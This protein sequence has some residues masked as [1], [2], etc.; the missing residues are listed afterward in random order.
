MPSCYIFKKAAILAIVFLGITAFAQHNV[1]I[2]NS[3]NQGFARTH[4]ITNGILNVLKE[5]KNVNVHVDYMDILTISKHNPQHKE[6]HE[7]G[8]FTTL[9]NKYRYVEFDMVI[10]I[11]HMAF[12]FA[13]QHGNNLWTGIP[14]V[15][16]GIS[17]QQAKSINSSNFRWYGIYESY[18]VRAQID[19]IQRLQNEVKKII[20]ITDRSEAGRDISEQL[21]TAK[22]Y[23]QQNINLEEWKEPQ[24]E[25]IP[26]L[27]SNLDSTQDAVVLA[28]TNL[29]DSIKN[30]QT[31]WHTLTAYINKHS[32]A[33]IY[34]F[35]DVGVQNGVIGGNVISAF[36][37]G[38][39][40]GL[41]AAKILAKDSNFPDFQKSTNIHVLDDQAI[42]NRNL[43]FDKI[44]LETVRLN[45]AETWLN[46]YQHYMSNMQNAIIAELVIIV[47]LSFSFYMYFKYSNRKLLKEMNAVKEASKAKS[48][49][50]A[51]MS[52]EIRTPLNSMLGFSELLLNKG[53]NLNEEQ[54]EWCKSIEIS[55]YHLRDTL[56]NILDFSKME[57]GTLKIEEEWVDV[58]ALCDELISVCRHHLFYKPV[59]FDVIPSIYAPR[60]IK[61]DPVKLKQVLINLVSNAL[62]FTTEG[63]VQLMVKS[64]TEPDENGNNICFE[65]IDTGIGI[66]KEKIEKIFEAFVQ[67]DSGSSRKYGGSGLGLAISQNILHAMNSHLEVQSN[68]SGS[69]FYFLL[70]VK[71]RKKEYYRKFLNRKNQKVALHNQDKK[72]L[73][74]LRECVEAVK[75][76]SVETTDLKTILNLSE[77]DLLIA[78]ADRLTPSQIEEIST[79]YPRSVLVFYQEDDRL[80]QIKRNFTNIECL[81]APV[82]S[83]EA[84]KALQKL[85]PTNA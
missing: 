75:G 63:S 82:K 36:H 2:L 23:Y 11:D 1:L 7:L 4:E 10:T 57:A 52:H 20:F 41:L 39:S 60:Y 26:R 19:F 12:N 77:Y 58:F 40:T 72:L 71:T 15:S 84:I 69:R 67:I 42:A 18:D 61:T 31:M 62:K 56:N 68:K 49:F 3:H 44:P 5:N 48:L 59:R 21:N 6:K 13:K 34:S 70:S 79:R 45:R 38:K 37:M 66:P 50:F 47:L 29:N 30:L 9:E 64:L 43:R 22:I 8:M 32:Q 55:S 24:W 53:Y 74:Y 78:E 51:N 83:E 73:K 35:W 25:N 17:E 81:M 80:Y 14:V 27:L 54:K 85:Y 46:R 33:P 76:T 65:V 28:G 16:C